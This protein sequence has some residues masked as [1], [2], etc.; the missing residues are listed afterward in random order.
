MTLTFALKI[1][2]EIG[3]VLLI[4]YGIYNEEKLVAFEK[5]IFPV[6]K[7]A[8]RKYILGEQKKVIKKSEDH[9]QV[10]EIEVPASVFAEKKNEKKGEKRAQIRSFPTSKREVSHINVA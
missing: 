9:I 1:F 7:F 8:F 6:L 4:A 5:E 3:M 10:K 2:F